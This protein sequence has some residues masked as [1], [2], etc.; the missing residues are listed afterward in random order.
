MASHTAAA[1][2]P[3]E[4]VA[5][6]TGPEPRFGRRPDTSSKPRPAVGGRSPAPEHTAN[7]PARRRIAEPVV[8]R[9]RPAAKPPVEPPAA[10]RPER[11]FAAVAL[12]ERRSAAPAARKPVAA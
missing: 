7:R 3:V 11:N 4:L 10:E 9:H 2:E 5:D 6:T 12:A 1:A 8:A